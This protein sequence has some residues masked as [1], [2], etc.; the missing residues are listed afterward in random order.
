[1]E[2]VSGMRSQLLGHLKNLG[3]VRQRG[4]GDMKDLNTNSQNISV[5]KAAALTGV[6]PALLRVDRHSMKIVSETESK[7][8]VHP[9]SV[10]YPANGTL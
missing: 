1:M 9:S 10:L 6:Y 4:T 8:R 3:L 5:V 7:V 2:M